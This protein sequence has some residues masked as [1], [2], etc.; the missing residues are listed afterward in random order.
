MEKRQGIITWNDVHRIVKD[1]ERITHRTVEVGIVLITTPAGRPATVAHVLTHTGRHENNLARDA[2]GQSV[3]FGGS[4]G[5][6]APAALLTGIEA[7]L[8]ADNQEQAQK[9]PAHWS[10]N[11]P[12][13]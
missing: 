4:T 8:E 2:R 10:W 13:D 12:D 9:A 5:L 11:L 6:S 1:Y 7:L 3:E